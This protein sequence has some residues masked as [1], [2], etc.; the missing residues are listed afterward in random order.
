MTRKHEKISGLFK[1]ISFIVIILN[2]EFNK[3]CRKKNHILFYW[4]FWF[5]QV[6]PDRFGDCTRKKNWWLLGCWREQKYVRF[7]DGF[8]KIYVIEWNSSRGYKKSG[9]GLTRIQTTS[10]SDHERLDERIKE[11]GKKS[12]DCYSMRKTVFPNMH[13]GNSFSKTTTAKVSEVKLICIEIAGE[14]QNSV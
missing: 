2:R 12:R 14:R 5:Q 13:T 3:T 10:H 4:I 9:R 1:E 7:M 6:N 8:H 11:L